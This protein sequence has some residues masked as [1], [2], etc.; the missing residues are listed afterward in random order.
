MPS[1]HTHEEYSLHGWESTAGK[2]LGQLKRQSLKE[3]TAAKPRCLISHH[4][5]KVFTAEKNQNH[6]KPHHHKG[7]VVAQT[8]LGQVPQSETI[9]G[10]WAVGLDV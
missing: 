3:S 5:C 7:H 4:S 1:P 8:A 2:G 10:P 9:N 6:Q